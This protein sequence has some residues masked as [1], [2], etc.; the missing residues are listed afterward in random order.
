L[1]QLTAIFRCGASVLHLRLVV[2]RGSSLLTG[3]SYERK[4][5]LELL[6]AYATKDRE[7]QNDVAVPF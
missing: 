6:Q 7:R 5:M 2:P 4:L 1:F 3:T